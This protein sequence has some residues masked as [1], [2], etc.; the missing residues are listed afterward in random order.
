M[1]VP[2]HLLDQSAHEGR[3][4][5]LGGW[6][7]LSSWLGSCPTLFSPS[8]HAVRWGRTLLGGSPRGVGWILGAPRPF[9]PC[10]R[11]APCSGGCPLLGLLSPGAPLLPIGHAVHWYRTL[12]YGGV[13]PF[14]WAHPARRWRAR[15][16]P[17]PPLLPGSGG[18]PPPGRAFHAL[19]AHAA[20]Q[21]VP[22]LRPGSARAVCPPPP[23]CP[24]AIFARNW[25]GGSPSSSWSPSSG[26][27][28]RWSAWELPSC[29]RCAPR[30]RAAGWGVP[31]PLPSLVT[32]PLPLLHGRL[33]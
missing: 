12:P 14:L 23:S 28:P 5:L 25:G 26:G 1:G 13:P 16:V 32:L 27:V 6:P 17:C 3:A 24:R 33:Y 19:G 18:F 10:A 8:L 9:M 2:P 21:G 31:L 22:P 30:A 20:V 11:S 4:H 7:P 15:S 29:T